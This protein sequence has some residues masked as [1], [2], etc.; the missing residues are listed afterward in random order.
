MAPPLSTVSDRESQVFTV[1]LLKRG[2][3]GRVFV[4]VLLLEVGDLAGQRLDDRVVAACSVG[5]GRF[6]AGLVTEPFDPAPELG[7]SVEKGVGDAG[8]TLDGLEGNRLAFLDQTPDGLVSGGCFRL[9]LGPG[10]GGEDGG[11]AGADVVHGCSSRGCRVPMVTGTGPAGGAD[12]HPAPWTARSGVL[13]MAART[14]A[15]ASCSA[16]RWASQTL[17]PGMGRPW[18]CRKSSRARSMRAFVSASCR[19]RACRWVLSVT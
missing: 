1:G 16:C 18:R 14:R 15:S 13:S 3:Q 2:P 19:C 8:L 7:V 17:S 11:A 10:R 4:A 9:G 5:R 12:G 6:R